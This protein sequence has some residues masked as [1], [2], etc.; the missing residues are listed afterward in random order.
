MKKAIKQWIVEVL[1]V[2]VLL[3]SISLF[4]DGIPLMGVPKAENVVSV[5]LL[6]SR[7]GGEPVILTEKEDIELAVNAAN[8]LNY[9]WGTPA[10]DEKI[11]IVTYETAMG[12]TYVL[13]A[14]ETCVW[15]KG[16]VY[17]LKDESFF[18]NV[19]EGCFFAGV[20]E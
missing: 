11:M 12:E 14:S 4:R 7:V 6:Y 13:S 3:V 9:R 1:I 5:E 18:I 2:T 15:W 20:A 19:M 16:K 10:E 8:F 17:P